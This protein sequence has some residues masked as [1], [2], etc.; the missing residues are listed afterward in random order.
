MDDFSNKKLDNF[1]NDRFGFIIDSRNAQHELEAARANLHA[2]QANLTA[3]TAQA[4][5]AKL[6]YESNKN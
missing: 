1:S 4:N 3:A 6:E 2:A 5:S